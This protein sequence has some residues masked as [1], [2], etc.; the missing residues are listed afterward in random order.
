[1]FYL[2]FCLVFGTGI[3]QELD[4]LLLPNQ[5]KAQQNLRASIQK[6]DQVQ[7]SIAT[8]R[9]ALLQEKERLLQ[10]RLFIL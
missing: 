2:F 3:Q 6:A 4:T 9:T 5:H 7:Q 1:M 10:V 8:A